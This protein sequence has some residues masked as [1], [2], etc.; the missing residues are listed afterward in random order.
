LNGENINQTMNF[1]YLI[2]NGLAVLIPVVLSF[3]RKVHYYKRWKYLFPSILLT[4]AVF[5]AWD[6][7]F[8]AK[9]VWGFNPRHLTGIHIFNLPLEECLFF[10]TIPYAS[11]FLFD[12]FKAYLGK[13]LLTKSAPVISIILIIV[14]FVTAIIYHQQ[15]YTFITFISLAIILLILQFY[16]R[17]WYIGNFYFTYLINLIPFLIVNGVLTGSYIEEEVVW[18]NSAEIMNIRLFT[19]PLEDVFYGMLLILINVSIYEKLQEKRR[20][21]N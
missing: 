21:N 8:T 6:I 19:I 3:D 16:Q 18:Y 4:A 2:I 5:I 11:V 14:L 12:V 9:G 15:I 20:S 17:V 1:T 7:A 10:V 13:N